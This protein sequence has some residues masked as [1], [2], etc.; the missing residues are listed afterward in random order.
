MI[1][2]KSQARADGNGDHVNRT[3][4]WL[5]TGSAWG[6]CLW[7]ALLLQSLPATT[8]GDHGVCGPWGCGPP[9]PVLLACHVFWFVLLGPPAVLAA[10]QLP[11]RWVRRLAT[12][13]VALATAGLVAV[14]GWEAAT[15][16]REASEW[17]RQYAI[18][19]YFFEVI[20][21]VDLPI[22]EVLIIG[23]CLWLAEQRRAGRP[24]PLATVIADEPP[25]AG[26]EFD[27]HSTA[28]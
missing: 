28:N 22:L 17:Q 6:V 15:W 27:A 21:L 13:M 16:F 9:V 23:G 25:P 20:T 2:P 19:R 24:V 7:W 26:E 10:G 12:V 5:L 3:I 18:H 4:I 1:G 14:G 11:G 8:F